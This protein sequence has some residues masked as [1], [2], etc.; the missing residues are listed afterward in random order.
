MMTER[1]LESAEVLHL[2]IG[3]S[4][5]GRWWRGGDPHGRDQMGRTSTDFVVAMV[6]A[7]SAREGNVADR[8]KDLV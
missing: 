3:D 8:A 2:R 6:I 1:W 5:R 4:R 7:V